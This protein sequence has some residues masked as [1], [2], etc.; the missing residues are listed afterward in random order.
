MPSIRSL[1]RGSGLLAAVA[2]AGVAAAQS[3]SAGSELGLG[4]RL[5][6]RFVVA[7]VVNL[8]LGGALVAFGPRFAEETV[9]ELRED[10]GGAFLW[11]L[12]VGVG[13]PILLVLLAITVIGLVVAIPGAIALAI[14]GLVGNAVTVVWVGSLFLG[15]DDIGGRTAAA[16]ALTLAVPAAIPV[17]GQLL[18]SFLGLF[19][20][21][22]VGRALYVSW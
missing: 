17:L 13:V 5:G 2:L 1:A 16:G 4:T 22:V 7:F 20:L 10:P 8:L 14:V 19:G 6:I 11:G 9:T 12:A 18:T 15:P 3:P 21:G